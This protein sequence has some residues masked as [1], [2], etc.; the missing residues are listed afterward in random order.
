MEQDMLEVR[1]LGGFSLRRGEAVLEVGGRSRKLYLL[2][3]RLIHERG[4]DV[5]YGELAAM[6]WPGEELD[7]AAWRSLKALIHRARCLLDGLGGGAGKYLLNRNG[8]C[9]FDPAVPVTLDAEE[10][11]A[12]CQ[13]GAEREDLRLERWTGA[14]A[15]YRGDFLPAAGDCP[16]ALERAGA[17]RRL[18]L[19]VMLD[20]LPLLA[21]EG[22][23]EQAAALSEGALALEPCHEG[24]CRR[25]R[26]SVV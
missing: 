26:K 18:W 8:L 10:F 3:A 22:R 12:L 20:T 1:M 25:D 24:L 15:L 17:L 9:R 6:L 23:W 14:L 21:G 2:L 11:S 19:R 13:E 4:R 5:P 7:E 16:W